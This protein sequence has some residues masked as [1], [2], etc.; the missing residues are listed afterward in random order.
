MA[1]PFDDLVGELTPGQVGWLPL[2]EAGN[3]TGPATISPPPPP[4]L[5]CSVMVNPVVPL[6]EGDDLLLSSTGAPLSVPLVSNVEKRD[7]DWVGPTPP[8]PAA[9]P[10]ITSISPNTAEIGSADIEMIVTGTGFTSS[11]IITFIGLD[12]PTDFFSE[13][14]VGTGVKPSLFVSAQLCPVTVRNG[15]V[16]SNSVDFEFTAPVGRK[17]GDDPIS[18][19]PKRK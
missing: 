18:T 7:D 8:V 1:G 6:P 12:E 3:P 11:S 2:D 19:S 4:A 13:T 16:H 14:S 9:P 5:A 17:R 15:D 10:V